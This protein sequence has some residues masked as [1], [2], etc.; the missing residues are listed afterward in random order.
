VGVDEQSTQPLGVVF[1][2]QP[3]GGR[4]VEGAV[5]AGAMTLI[6]E[7]VAQGESEGARVR[8]RENGEGGEPLGVAGGHDP[9]HLASPIVTHEVKAMALIESAGGRQVEH[10]LDEP[11]DAIGLE[12]GGRIGPDAG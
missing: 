1:E 4:V 5:V 9:R 3:G 10:V 2:E 6:V 11:V 7:V 12:A 8:T